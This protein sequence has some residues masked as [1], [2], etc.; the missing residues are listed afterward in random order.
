MNI[1]RYVK[2]EKPNLG[3]REKPRGLY[4]TKTNWLSAQHFSALHNDNNLFSV[5]QNT[6]EKSCN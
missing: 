4:V 1:L 5:H 6:Q 3:E 2:S